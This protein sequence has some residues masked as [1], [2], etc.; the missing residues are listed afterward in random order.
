[1]DFDLTEAQRELSGLAREMLADWAERHPRPGDTG[2]DPE[3]WKAAAS[4]GLLEAALPER[5]DGGGYGLLEQCGVLTE[6]GRA[7]APVPYSTSIAVVAATLAEFGDD[8]QVERWVRPLLRGETTVA[9]ALA[10]D[11]VSVESERDANGW[12]VQGSQSVVAAG[13]FAD[14]F[15]VEARAGANSILLLLDR[16]VDGLTVTTQHAVNGAD[17]ALLELRDVLVPAEQVITAPDAPGWAGRRAA[18]AACALQLGILERALE[19]TC[20]YACTRKQFDKPIGSFQAVRQRL[21][22]AYIDVEAVRLTLWQAA[23]RE[24]HGLPAESE[25]GVAKFWAAEAGHRVAH[26][27]VHIHASTGIYLD[28]PMQRYFTAAKRA[29]FEAGTATTH[30]RRLGAYLDADVP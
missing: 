30:L 17:A 24:S 2:F 1:M 20:E 9:S 15:L 29:E 23:W 10:R 12:R 19:M 4:A 16:G 21:A 14:G 22:D 28:Y 11:F 13:A 25:I 6:I 3:L 7:V 26:T 18:L 5:V 27:A 8:S